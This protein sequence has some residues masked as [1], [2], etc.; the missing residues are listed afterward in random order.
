MRHWRIACFC[1]H[2]LKSSARKSESLTDLCLAGPTASNGTR[3]A[4]LHAGTKH[5]AVEVITH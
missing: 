4:T 5:A 2:A 3:L 1:C